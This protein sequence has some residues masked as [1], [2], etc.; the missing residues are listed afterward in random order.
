MGRARS[1]TGNIQSK[2]IFALQAS[3]DKSIGASLLLPSGN[4]AHSSVCGPS[5][6]EWN[7]LSNVVTSQA[8]LKPNTGES[9]LP[10]AEARES[11]AAGGLL[12]VNRAID[13]DSAARPCHITLRLCLHGP[14]IGS[15]LISS[16]KSEEK[17]RAFL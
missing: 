7:R 10:K 16:H 9:L 5:T 15:W 4:T 2:K 12:P 3:R 8:A 1:R 6:E 11:V 13:G 17:E 14:G